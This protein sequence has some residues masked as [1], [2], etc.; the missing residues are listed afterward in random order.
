MRI[1]G[2]LVAASLLSGFAST[3]LAQQTCEETDSVDTCW[4]NFYA[5]AKRSE[6]S[7][8]ATTE[9]SKA[10]TEATKAQTGADSGGA[11]TASTLTDL[12]PLFDALGLIGNSDQ[13]DGT[14][15]LN[16]NFL[17]PLQ[18]ADKNMRLQ[19]V[20]N[21]SPEPLTALVDAFPEAVRA[22]RKDTLQKEISTFGDSRAEL[23]YSL[24]NSRFGRDFT[25]AR[26]KLA[27]I[28][29]G[30]WARAGAPAANDSM[31]DS[32]RAALQRLSDN[33]I[34]NA[35]GINN[36]TAF[37][38]YPAELQSL[39]DELKQ[40]S[41]AFGTAIGKATL[42]TQQEFAAARLS[43]LAALVEQQP[44]LLFS[45]AQD[46]RDDVVGPEK[47]SAK[48]TFEFTRY[49][50]G[51][52]LRGDGAACKN[53]DAVRQGGADY[54]KCV[55][56]LNRYAGG[57]EDALKTQPRWKLSAAYQRVKAIDYLYPDDNVTLHLPETDR[58]EVTVGW[59]RPLQA[60]KNADRVDLEASYD[61]NIDGDT[62]NKE[63]IKATFTYTRRVADMDIPFSIVYANKDQFLGEVDHQISLNLGIKFRPPP[64]GAK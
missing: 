54:V 43:Q 52:F 35:K 16:L 48:L 45:V 23:T 56:A 5:S 13:S 42:A 7:K 25:V 44:Q 38:A 37:S 58:V 53:A 9:T 24:V 2:T 17:L 64:G 11:A 60:V 50:L 21:T 47:T 1:L 34:A 39:R 51:D 14:L 6:P 3:A 12:L 63:R 30:A 61:S 27:P 36:S 15:A 41:A 46:I 62:S 31:V 32:Q 22:A 19:V 29:E 40:Q 4:Q 26:R 57:T 59:G 20:V 28:Y 33:T 8:F 49:N 55:D 10:K 18:E